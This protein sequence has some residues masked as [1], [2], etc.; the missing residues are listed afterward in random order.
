MAAGSKSCPRKQS[1]EEEIANSISHAIGFVAASVATPYFLS[2]VFRN[3]QTGFAVGTAI[4][5]A[6]VLLLYFAS[7]V[8]HALPPGKAKDLFKTIEHSA[9]YLLIA[10]TYT[11]FTL[12]VLRGPWG[13]ALL[14]IIWTC[15]IGGV[16][17]K[18]CQKMP[19]P[20]ASTAL[21][22]LMG[23]LL[24]VAAKPLFT[25]V[26]LSGLLWIAAGGAAYTLGVVFFAYDS[27]IRFGHFIW[28]LFVMLGT[29]CHFCAVIWYGG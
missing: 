15:A 16:V 12:G 10:G 1:P 3:G 7:S 13:L 29:A 28:H 8:Y 22:L 25:F 11:P 9:I 24:V 21:Y 17:W 6:T 4:F 18:F 26:P 2:Q 23:W 20:V 27:R 14:V 19:S 5:T